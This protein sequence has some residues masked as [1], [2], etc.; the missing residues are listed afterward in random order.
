MLL[1]GTRDGLYRADAVP[2]KSAER[3]LDAGS[4]RLARTSAGAFA[5]GF[6]GCFR[7]SDGREWTELDVP[8]GDRVTGVGEAPDGTLYA[9]THPPARLWASDDGG[10]SWTERPFPD[11]DAN[12][13][14]DAD[15]D[16][17][18]VTIEAGGNVRTFGFHPDAPDR[19]VAGVEPKGVFVSEDRGETWE[20]RSHGTVGDVHTLHVLA[21]DRWLAATGGG[22]YETRNAGE[23]WQRL[24]TSQHYL[25][26]TYFTDAASLDGRLYTA[27]AHGPPG[28]WM[29]EDGAGCVLLESDDDGR[30]F[31]HVP[32]PG[33]PGEYV[34]AF[35]VHD[36]TVVAGTMA[37]DFH[38]DG[39][40][41]A[42]VIYRTDDGW[43]DAGQMPAGV[44][45]L[46][47]L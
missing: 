22:L 20:K 45:S 41:E 26:R 34:R 16:E 24:D 11:L 35:A 13:R 3:V 42:R 7:S 5:F 40:S 33:G 17:L 18:V 4:L 12:R 36:G 6:D 23:T 21:R 47:A 38:E 28:T 2:F 37:Q 15:A 25:Q 8:A 32:F 43:R 46:A 44:M 30:S 29:G 31:E 27:A 9:G 19:V 1:I 10:G 14:Y 39:T